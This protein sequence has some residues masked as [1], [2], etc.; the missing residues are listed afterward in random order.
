M[1]SNGIHKLFYSCAN[2]TLFKVLS[3]KIVLAEFLNINNACNLSAAI[4]QNFNLSVML[5]FVELVGGLSD[6]L[7]LRFALEVQKN[8]S[9]FNMA[10]F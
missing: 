1:E 9:F 3:F 5:L 10:A 4:T 7:K 8:S 6:P 2:Y